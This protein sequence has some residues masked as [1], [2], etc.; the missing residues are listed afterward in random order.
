MALEYV[1]IF[2][3]RA[4]KYKPKEKNNELEY[5]KNWNLHLCNSKSTDVRIFVNSYNLH[6]ADIWNVQRTPKNQ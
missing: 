1:K 4:N 2:L 3:N 6:R 5:V